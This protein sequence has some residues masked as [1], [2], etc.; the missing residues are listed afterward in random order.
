M[1]STY[2][3][4]DKKEA[5]RTLMV[6]R[7]NGYTGLG[8]ES[9]NPHSL[10]FSQACGKSQILFS[11]PHPRG[12]AKSEES[13]SHPTKAPSQLEQ[14]A[15]L[16]GSRKGTDPIPPD[17]YRT[18]QDKRYPG[19]M[20]LWSWLLEHSIAPGQRNGPA[21][22]KGRPVKLTEAAL[23]LKMNGTAIR[24]AWKV[25]EQEN[26]VRREKDGSLWIS[27]DFTLG[28]ETAKKS[29][30][31]LFA[32][33]QLR[34]INKL[35]EPIRK[36][37]IAEELADR[38]RRDSA[39]A[40]LVASARFIFDERQ[41]SRFQR[42]GVKIIREKQKAKSGK[43]AEKTDRDRRVLTAL[44]IVANVVQTFFP[45]EVVQ[46]QESFVQSEPRTA[47]SAATHR[48]TTAS[49]KAPGVLS[50]ENRE[51]SEN[52]GVG[53]SV[54]GQTHLPTA[55]AQSDQINAISLMLFRL[56]GNKL[57]TR[58]GPK[59]AHMVLEKIGNGTL[60]S[61]E[62]R[63][64]LRYDAIT[65]YGMIPGLA[66]DVAASADAPEAPA[67]GSTKSERHEAQ[68]DEYFRQRMRQELEQAGRL[69]KAS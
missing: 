31:N 12:R 13:L 53:M 61:L 54:S 52:K 20:R 33:Y 49:E 57:N 25:L 45:E 15:A 58:P 18:Y 44:P 28:E 8:H 5:R 4:G 34:E 47:K 62:E 43:E 17:Q 67:P 56:L 46:L 36:Q 29:L 59:I 21:T 1:V 9:P 65:S 42:Y 66:A 48:A 41:N 38:K 22:S 51:R 35:P 10:S 60:E 30:Y 3:K 7:P 63:I 16:I 26:R 68:R 6:A 37:F 23:A 40:D 14:F 50:S 69:D 24:E 39:I 55:A 32:D 27:G 2:R 64:L 11:G 19:P